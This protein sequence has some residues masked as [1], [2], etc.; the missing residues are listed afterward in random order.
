MLRWA[1]KRAAAFVVRIAGLLPARHDGVLG[2][3]VAFH[4][5]NIDQFLDALRCE[6]FAIQ[7]EC[8][9]RIS[10]RQ[11]ALVRGGDR[12]FGGALSGFDMPDFLVRF[13]DTA[14][15]K[16]LAFGVRR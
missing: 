15:I 16:G 11:Q 1:G 3:T 14:F 6:A 5:C 10:A 9:S 13:H 2:D 7:P 8:C 12:R 4:Q